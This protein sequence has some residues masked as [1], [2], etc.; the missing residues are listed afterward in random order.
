MIVLLHCRLTAQQGIGIYFFCNQ[1]IYTYM[2][3]EQMEAWRFAVNCLAP[4]CQVLN[5]AQNLQLSRH[6]AG[7]EEGDWGNASEGAQAIA[8]AWPPFF[9][10]KTDYGK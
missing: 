8:C 5:K 3:A 9:L 4:G 2:I 1:A 10:Q 7:G 6:S